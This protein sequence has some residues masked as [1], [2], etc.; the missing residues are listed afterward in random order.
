[1]AQ[2][3]VGLDLGTSKICAIVASVEGRKINILGVGTSPSDGLTRGAVANIERTAQAI[4]EAVRKAENQS[5]VKI[6]SVNVGIA[7]PGIRSLSSRHVITTNSPS[8]EI[9]RQD[10][11]RLLS[12][13]SRIRLPSDYQILHVLPQEFIIDNVDGIK[14]PVGMSG[15]KVEAIVHIVTALVT[16][17]ENIKKC[18]HRAGLNIDS[19]ILEP[20]ASS[21]SVLDKEEK[22][23][24][25]ALVDIGAGTTDI[26]V[27]EDGVIRYTSSIGIAGNQITEDIRRGLGIYR[28]K[29]EEL[30]KEE[31][32]AYQKVLVEDKSIT[33]PGMGGRKPFE[34]TR[35]FLCEI[36]QVRVEEIFEL[37]YQDLRRSGY[38]KNLY[39]GIVLTGGSSLLK[40][41]VELVQDMYEMPARL[42]VP[43][44][45]DGGL[46]SEIKNPIY[47]TATGLILGSIHDSEIFAVDVDF[48][49][50]GLRRFLNWMKRFFG[51][52]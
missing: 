10:V 49:A 25:V 3:V 22:E 1:M 9:T 51:E 8:H 20:L 29:A 43:T 23:I 13:A 39:A 41:I 27:F 18:V 45:F 28:N 33:I 14:D 17:I 47:A 5:G 2:V 44:G 34:I 21:Y 37:V 4:R 35:R 48:E 40:G 46:V 12:E 42:G 38:L 50:R 19:I 6:K 7:G 26:A 15:I 24:G 32:Y 31:G 11:D 16:P 52:I 36:I 30:K